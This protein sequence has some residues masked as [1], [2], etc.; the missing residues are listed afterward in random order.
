MGVDLNAAASR[1]RTASSDW[2]NGARSRIGAFRVPP[3]P[4]SFICKGEF[5]HGVGAAPTHSWNLQQLDPAMGG[6][7]RATRS[8]LT[9]GV[10]LLSKVSQDSGAFAHG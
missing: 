8:L 10:K 5:S 7:G 9:R 2:L 6:R 1:R 4:L 3:S